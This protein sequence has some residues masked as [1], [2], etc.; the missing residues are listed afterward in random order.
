MRSALPQKGQRATTIS[1]EGMLST[2]S[3]QKR[4]T[5]SAAS[6]SSIEQALSAAF[7]DLEQS[8][9]HYEVKFQPTRSIRPNSNSMHCIGH[10]DGALEVSDYYQLAVL[11][12][13][14][15]QFLHLMVPRPI[16]S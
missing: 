5:V 1:W 11:R 14:F 3:T 12:K 9:V 4:F 13:C 8:L 2:F 10:V 7:V 16:E 6:N 15:K